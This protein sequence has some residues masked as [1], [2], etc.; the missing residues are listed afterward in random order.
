MKTFYCYWDKR[1]S[2]SIKAKSEEEA[3]NKIYDGNYNEKDVEID[4]GEVFVEKE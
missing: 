2:V 4:D 1:Y 3:I